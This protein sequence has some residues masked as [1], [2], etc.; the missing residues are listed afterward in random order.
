MSKYKSLISLAIMIIITFGSQICTLLK[1]SL[2]AA[3]FGATSA[4]DAY[5][6][7]NSIA[8]FLFCFFSA[9]MSTIVIPRYVQKDSKK[10]INTF[11]TIIFCLIGIIIFT[12]AILRYQIIGI[13]SNREEIFVNIACNILLILLFSNYLN[14]ITGITAAYFQCEGRYNIPKV[15]NLVSQIAVLICLLFLKNLSIYQYAFIMASGVLINFIFDVGIAFKL[16]WRYR[17]EFLLNSP[18]T[19][20]LFK[21]FLPIVFS[22]GIYQ[23]SL[24]IDSTIAARLDEGMLTILSYSTQI[25]GMINSI[26]IGNLLVYLYPKIVKR[27]KENNNKVVFWNQVSFFHLIICLIITGYFA[28]GHEGVTLLFGHGKFGAYETYSVFV[29]SLI[30]V[31]GQQTNIVRDLIYRYF[32]A[33]GDTKTAATNSLLVSAVNIT[34]SL[35]LVKVIGFYGIILG[36]VIAS[37]VSLVRIFIQ[38]KKKIGLGIPISRILNTLLLNIIISLLTISVVSISKMILHIDSNFIRILFFGVET[39]L[40]FCGFSYLLK[41]KEI[42]SVVSTL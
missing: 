25:S 37:F 41:K 34:V 12:V 19:K 17:P 1:S 7:A 32:Y 18:E 5:N 24:I 8:S 26:I 15:I 11:I 20:K 13:F 40:I 16:G 2:V 4:M 3:T 33:I 38:Y 9:A 23:L 39:V 42:S 36:T 10:E 22:T 29:G 6:F 27:I 28:V 31:V 35:I 30:Y 14:T 21:L